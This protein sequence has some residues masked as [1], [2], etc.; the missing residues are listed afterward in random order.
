MIMKILN[1][2]FTAAP[3]LLLTSC[4]A[5]V[6]N[7]RTETVRVDGDC[8]MCEKTI[9]K[10]AYVKGEAEADWDVDAKVARITYDSIRTDLDAVLKRIALAGYDSKMYLAPDEAYAKLPGCCQYE[11]TFKQRALQEAE[12]HH[13]ANAENAA[14][15]SS[16]GMPEPAS[17]N[18][19]TPVFEHY[20]AL[21]DALVAS[22]AAEAKEHAEGLDGAMHSVDASK[23]PADQ[24]PMWTEV[25]T[26]TMPSLHPLSEST[27]LDRQRTL[28]AKLAAPMAQLAK[29]V[30]QEAAIY[31]DHCPM[32]N[33][34]ADWLS[35]DKSIKNPF[36]GDMMLSCGSV[37]E[38][39]E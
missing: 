18:P 23:L 5:Q 35:R 31:V 20:F 19:F 16:A 11:R 6:K 24:Q 29:A 27:D 34:G 13:E 4:A 17:K 10:V 25:M 36:Y 9:E 32:Y 38:T 2:L 26:A 7:A 39:I 12:H 1:H 21:K 28:F 22:N 37:K 8:P 30:P 14:T 3:F 33:G 15:D